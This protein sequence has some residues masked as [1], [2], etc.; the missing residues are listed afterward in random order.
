MAGDT[1]STEVL[2]LEGEIDLH[3]SPVI[4]QQLAAI[5]D[6]RPACILVDL[7]G[8]SYMDSSGLAVLVEALQKLSSNGGRLGLF[9]LGQSVRHIFEIARLDQVFRIFP[10]EAAARAALT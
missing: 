5:I 3:R 10:D 6:R 7:G 4:K 8:V 2:A 1:N 9:G